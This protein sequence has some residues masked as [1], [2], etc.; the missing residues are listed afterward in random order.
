MIYLITLLYS[1]AFVPQ[2]TCR[3]RGM[4]STIGSTT[5]SSFAAEL[6]QKYGTGQ[7]NF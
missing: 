3:T 4:P 6:A 5:L 2:A 7:K 1:T